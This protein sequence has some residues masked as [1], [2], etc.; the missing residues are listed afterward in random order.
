MIDPADK[1]TA[2]LPLEQTKRGRGRPKTG[3]ALTPAQK[4]KAY[5]NRLKSNVTEITVSAIDERMELR[6]QLL[7]ALKRAEL[8]EAE[9]DV[10]GN[11]LAVIKAK[12]SRESR[13]KRHR[14][15]PPVDLKGIPD[16]GVWTV[17]FMA[18]SLGKR[19]WTSCEKPMVDFEGV[20]DKFEY[21][22]SHVDH[23][24]KTAIRG[25]AWRAVRDDGL[26]YEA[27]VPKSKR[28]QPVKS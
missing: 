27:K 18:K 16:E 28:K 17:E 24:Q 5:R 7:E 6:E 3:A 1:Q 25:N 14:D 11:E 12:A 8:A 21:V 4:Q 20:P 23:M 10:M 22:K 9:R 2:S 26:I 15:D 13:V 19:S